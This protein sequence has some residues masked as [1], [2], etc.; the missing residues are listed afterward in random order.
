MEEQVVMIK[1]V[2]KLVAMG[3]AA[4][5]LITSTPAFAVSDCDPGYYIGNTKFLASDVAA[6]PG[7]LTELNTRLNLPGMGLNNFI[8]DIGN[9]KHAN[10]GLFRQ[11]Y[12]NGGIVEFL[13]FCVDHPAILYEDS[14]IYNPDGTLR[15]DPDIVGPIVQSILALN[16]TTIEVKISTAVDSAAVANFTLSK[17]SLS[18][19]NL[20]ADKKTATLTVNGLVNGDTLTV[21]VSGL[22]AGARNVNECTKTVTVPGA[23]VITATHIDIEASDYDILAT[24]GTNTIIKVTLKDA[25]EQ[26]VNEEATIKFTKTAGSLAQNEVA[27]ENGVATVQLTSVASATEVISTVTAEVID[28]WQYMGMLDSL[29]VYFNPVTNPVPALV[30]PVHVESNQA[31]R[32]FVTFSGPINA[33]DFA[34]A[35]LD[36]IQAG[37]LPAMVL[38]GWSD[39]EP[40]FLYKDENGNLKVGVRQVTPDTLEFVLNTDDA[41]ENGGTPQ[42]EKRFWM[43]TDQGYLRDNATHTILFTRDIGN[44]VNGSYDKPLSF[45]LVDALKPYIRGIN[46][47]KDQLTVSVQFS[48]AM[49]EDI[50]EALGQ[51]M[52]N[53]H[54]LIDGK[55]IQVIAEPTIQQV[56][57]AKANN[58]LI[59][60]SI[61]VGSYNAGN[62]VDNRNIVEIKLDWRFKLGAGVHTLQGDNVSDWAGMTDTNNVVSTQTFDF[63]VLP[64]NAPPVPT[65]IVQS[66]EQ[67]L[68]EFDKKVVVKDMVKAFEIRVGDSYQTLMNQG[69]DYVIFEL[70]NTEAKSQFLIEFTKDWTVYYDDSYKLPEG[71]FSYTNKGI[72]YFTP[73]MNPYKFIINE[74]WVRDELGNFCPTSQTDVT[75]N[76]DILSPQLKGYTYEFETEHTSYEAIRQRFGATVL[77]RSKEPVQIISNALCDANSYP[78]TPSVLQ[79][80]GTGVPTP[81]FEFVNQDTGL[82]VKGHVPADLSIYGIQETISQDDMQFVVV[83]FRALTPGNWNLVVR[84]ISD[85]V[86]NTNATCPWIMPIVVPDVP[87]PIT[88]TNVLWAAFENGCKDKIFVKFSEEMKADGD[89]GVQSTQNYIFNGY[90]LPENSNIYR[91]IPGVTTEWDGITIEMPGNTWNGERPDVQDGNIFTCILNVANNLQA[92]D[93]DQLTGPY[94]FEMTDVHYCDNFNGSSD[95]EAVYENDAL[96]P[97]YA[98]GPVVSA[99]FEDLKKYENTDPEGFVEGH[100]GKID[101][102]TVNLTPCFIFEDFNSSNNAM[103]FVN[104][105]EWN[106]EF[107]GNQAVLTAPEAV[108]QV[109]ASGN[110]FISIKDQDGNLLVNG[111]AY[112]DVAGPAIKSLAFTNNTDKVTVNF[113]ENI[114]DSTINPGDFAIGGDVPAGTVV[115]GIDIDPFDNDNTVVLIMNN[116]VGLQSGQLITAAMTAEDAVRDLNGNGNVQTDP[117]SFR[118]PASN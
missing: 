93:S 14:M 22:K 101:Q 30:S 32:F 39:R 117:V 51:N 90:Q 55:K 21:V 1:R 81:T 9:E 45:I 38:D 13:Q 114:D 5:M 70:F 49:A 7:M 24:G 46:D 105:E 85:D 104:G 63:N 57:L 66:P 52:I 94:E 103:F 28:P 12:P 61:Q 76:Q 42:I 15:P 112:N 54:F 43:G 68:L 17:G 86:G 62:G 96:H 80:R 75:L 11:H 41:F 73:V 95:F 23:V 113:S 40:P 78:L 27:L 35:Y 74:N 118:Q 116:N 72:N 106:Y 37:F 115:T 19:V 69:Q 16:A 25:N 83:P 60:T 26:I 97:A 53:N 47:V 107:L 99:V 31:D 59:A 110:V 102:I 50:V 58:M 98:D 18:A 91:G 67:W 79:S 33:A 65:L 44:L 10:Y 88:D 111:E 77:V 20:S 82:T 48:E 36:E 71:R 56:N 2:K 84:G 89:N 87:L 109:D 3:A 108:D 64:D 92:V 29:N 100:D 6:N 4:L 8:L 34:A